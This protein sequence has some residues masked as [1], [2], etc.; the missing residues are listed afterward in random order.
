MYDKPKLSEAEYV[1]N[2][3]SRCPM[4]NSFNIRTTDEMDPNGTIGLQ[5]VKCASCGATWQDRW[6]LDGYENITPGK[7][8]P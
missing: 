7:A 4:C 2:G 1:A 8:K 6:K 5:E 3:G